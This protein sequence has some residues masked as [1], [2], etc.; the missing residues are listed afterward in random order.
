MENIS[1]QYLPIGMIVVAAV[2]AHARACIVCSVRFL[3]KNVH[4]RQG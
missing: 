3:M 4:V 2:V 1:V